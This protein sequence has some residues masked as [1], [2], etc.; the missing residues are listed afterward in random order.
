MTE[1][2]IRYAGTENIID[3]Y[4]FDLGDCMSKLSEKQTTFKGKVVLKS[5]HQMFPENYI[6][7]HISVAYS[8]ILPES[9]RDAEMD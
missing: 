8:N 1:F 6:N 7:L 4:E 5:K 9:N 3:A 2:Q